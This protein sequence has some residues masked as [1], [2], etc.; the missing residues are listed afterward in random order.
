MN[1]QRRYTIVSIGVILALIVIDQ[2]IKILVK[3][4]MCIGETIPVF[5]H[6][7][8]ICFVENEGMAFG[9]SLGQNIGKLMLSL[10]R[11]VLIV[12]L[13]WYLHKKIKEDKMDGFKIA[14]FCM[15]IA[16]AMGNI[17]DSMFY[18]LIFTESTP[19]TVAQAFAG[20]YAP[21]LFGKVVDM[22]YFPLFL[23]PEKFP[24]WGGSYFF[25]AIFNFADSCITVGLIL[26]LI[27]NKRFFSDEVDKKE[28][29]M[30]E[31]APKTEN[32]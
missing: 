19:L 31:E 32:I 10:I 20:G 28:T 9:L 13:C 7:F 27:F 11:V 4:H 26:M 30:A 8:N 17:L 2:V 18:G 22:F 14:I 23:I 3:T 5:G 16:G 25:P 24:L 15:V 29:E 12:L 1:K 21:F 6:W